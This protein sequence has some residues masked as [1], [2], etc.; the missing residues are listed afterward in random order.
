MTILKNKMLPTL[1]KTAKSYTSKELL[2]ILNLMICGFCLAADA[3]ITKSVST[4]FFLEA[5]DSSFFPLAWLISLPLNFLVVFFYNKH[6]AY[7]G[8]KKMMGKALYST[9]IFNVL[10]AFLIKKSYILPFALYI[11]KEVFVMFMFHNLWSVIHSGVDLKRAKYLYGLFFGIGSLGSVFGGVVTFQFSQILGS[12]NLLLVTF[13]LYMI[14]FYVYCKG[15]RLQ[16]FLSSSQSIN[17]KKENASIFY[18]IKLVKNSKILLFILILVVSMQMSSTLIEYQ[19]NLQLKQVFD[20]LDLRTAFIGKI[21]GYVNMINVFIQFVGSFILVRV[22]GLLSLHL[23]IPI[24]LLNNLIVYLF[25]PS[26]NVMCLNYGM[27][28]SLDY[29]LF[30]I[31]VGM[32]YTPLS[33]EEKFQGKSIIS[34]LG[35]RGAKSVI[36]FLTLGLAFFNHQMIQSLLIYAGIIIFL[37]WI[38][39]SY[40]L[41]KNYQKQ[42][43]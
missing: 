10:C 14:T 13:P 24:L 25:I 40:S 5:Y 15:V 21:L 30:G 18:G 42:Y 28:K 39:S 3:A 2:F 41:K 37:I 27:I 34:I 26:F 9:A 29:S 1:Q 31:I 6:I 20:C 12:H 22:I 32:L 36:S 33:I 11:W 38:I 19:F 16:P 8:P 4:S 35:Y 43:I 17:L 7:F 23:L